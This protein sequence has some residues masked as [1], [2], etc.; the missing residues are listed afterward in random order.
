MELPPHLIKVLNGPHAGAQS[1]FYDGEELVVGNSDTADIFLSDP[2]ITPSHFMIKAEGGGYLVTPD[3]GVVLVNGRRIE[4]G[5]S[6]V[7]GQVVTA[8]STSLGIGPAEALWPPLIIPETTGVTAVD[9][10]SA[11]S[12]ENPTSSAGEKPPN[13]RGF[14]HGF[15]IAALVAVLAFSA[16]ALFFAKEERTQGV[17][18]PG[19]LEQQRS[20]QVD[21]QTIG[22]MKPLSERLASEIP[23]ATTII[24]RSRNNYQ[25]R[26]FVRGED[27]AKK[28]RRMIGES[29]SGIF[30]EVIDLEELDN[31]LA[32]IVESKGLTIKAVSTTN[33]SVVFHGYLRSEADLTPLSS[34]ISTDLPFLTQDTTDLFFGNKVAEEITAVL[35]SQ[36]LASLVTPVAKADGIHFQ[37]SLDEAKQLAWKKTLPMIRER[38]GKVLKGYDEIGADGGAAVSPELQKILGSPIAGVTFGNSGWIELANGIRLFQG[39]ALPNGMILQKISTREIVI[40]G[41]QG[42]V[43]INPSTLSLA[44]SG[45]PSPAPKKN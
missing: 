9:E 17:V 36:G 31:I 11:P 28:A 4:G 13:K 44:P 24:D 2:H 41:S 21:V 3:E 12:E 23:G 14:L 32:D 27:Q 39:S 18:Y 10:P 1:R 42:I 7:P 8:G 43:R 30:A 35:A 38:F 20:A 40:S 45:S 19:D 34:E 15:L 37:G 16:W 29:G 33:G 5:T 26:I 6:V 22:K 25:L